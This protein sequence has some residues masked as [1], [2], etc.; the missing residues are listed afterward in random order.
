MNIPDG[1][2]KQ[3]IGDRQSPKIYMWGWLGSSV[4][5]D[6]WQDKKAKNVFLLKIKS[7]ERNPLRL[8]RGFHV[9]EICKKKSFN[10]EIDFHKNGKTYTAP[11]G[12]SHY[13]QAHDYKPDNEVIDAIL[14]GKNNH[15]Y[16]DENDEDVDEYEEERED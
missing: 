16:D 2:H 7:K 6:G 8:C 4:P 1:S 9:C 10:G 15:W 11:C 5:N 3:Y 13:I 12:V 14:K